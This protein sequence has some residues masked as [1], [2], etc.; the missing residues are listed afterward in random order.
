LSCHLE[1]GTNKNQMFRRQSGGIE[2]C[3]LR[4]TAEIDESM[5]AREG[6]HVCCG[7]S[8][9]RDIGLASEAR[10]LSQSK[11][12]SYSHLKQSR[13]QQ[14]GPRMVGGQPGKLQATPVLG[15]ASGTRVVRARKKFGA[16]APYFM[17][18]AAEAKSRWHLLLGQCWDWN[19]GP[20]GQ[21][22]GSLEAP[23]CHGVSYPEPSSAQ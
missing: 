10:G 9:P 15:Q 20:V 8:R 13:P 17:N 1:A 21:S 3:V 11:G 7:S 5:G 6:S 23:G 2:T 16:V 18:V 4:G 12:Q 22:L 19:L 14:T